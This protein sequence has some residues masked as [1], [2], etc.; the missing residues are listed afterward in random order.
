MAS[1]KIL[2]LTEANFEQEVLKSDKPVLVDFWAE[3]CGP[4]KMLGPVLEQLAGD[5]DEKA[6][7]G[8]VDVDSNQ[9]LAAKYGITS[10]PQLFFFKNGEIVNQLTG[11][12]SKPEL[13]A[14]LDE[15]CA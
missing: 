15:A 8:K 7:I 4:C 1:D 2:T 9:A 6:K 3:W 14:A 11:L 13:S 10:I 12:R 5:Y